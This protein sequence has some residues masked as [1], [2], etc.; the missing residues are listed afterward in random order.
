MKS[1]PRYKIIRCS[2]WW[3][4]EYIW[5]AFHAARPCQHWLINAGY[6]E[7][8]TVAIPV[9]ISSWRRSVGRL[10]CVSLAE[11]GLPPLF[12]KLGIKITTAFRIVGHGLSKGRRKHGS[13]VDDDTHR[14]NW[15]FLLQVH[16]EGLH[17]VGW[18]SWWGVHV[19]L[20][21][22]EF[23][24][25]ELHLRVL[26]LNFVFGGPSSCERLV[27]T[28]KPSCRQSGDQRNGCGGVSNRKI[29][30]ASTIHKFPETLTGIL[31]DVKYPWFKSKIT[32]HT[33]S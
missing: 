32:L 6:R 23:A 25:E 21:W 14:S 28:S 17:C 13:A 26:K 9:V 8:G 5:L 1:N 24:F 27:E 31:E 11:V 33:A 16:E 15:V 30:R 19:Q 10:L 18:S 12:G 29:A 22:W 2:L 3:H 7:L 4:K 20:L